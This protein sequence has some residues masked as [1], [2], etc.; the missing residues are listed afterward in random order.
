MGGRD[1]RVKG[2]QV[3]GG[4][5][6]GSGPVDDSVVFICGKQLRSISQG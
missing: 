6:K 5:K 2:D 1:K 4:G 3:S